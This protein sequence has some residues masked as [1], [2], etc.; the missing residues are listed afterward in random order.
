MLVI[1]VMCQF[2]SSTRNQLPLFCA[3]FLRKWKFLQPKGRRWT[4]W[5]FIYSVIYLLA[6]LSIIVTHFLLM[7]GLTFCLD[8]LVHVLWTSICSVWCYFHCWIQVKIIE[9]WKFGKLLH[10]E[11]VLIFTGWERIWKKC[12]YILPETF[13]YESVSFWTHLKQA[14]SQSSPSSR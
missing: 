8:S 9:F 4:L 6:Q 7:F 2:P 14:F 11:V 10:V 1:L 5:S 12:P 3:A 13:I